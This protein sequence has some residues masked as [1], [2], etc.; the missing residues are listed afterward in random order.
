MKKSISY[1]AFLNVLKTFFSL[2]FPLITFPYASRIL[3]PEGIGKVQ[4]SH[5]IILYFTM[6]AGLG[7]GSYSV[8]EA[9]K[10]RNDEDKLTKIVKEVLII[11]LVSTF[12]AYALLVCA[13]FCIPKFHDY[14]VLLIVYSGTILFTTLGMD[15]LYTA[16]EEFQYITIR[17]F[18]FQLI[19]LILLFIFV[20]KRTDY[21]IYAAISVVSNVGSNICN[22]I[23]SRKYVSYFTKCK[24]ELKR[25]IKPIFILFGMQIV[26]SVYLILDTTVLGFISGDLEVGYY[27]AATK[28][29]KIVVALVSS[30]FTVF[31]P[32]LSSLLAENERQA[33]DDL[34]SKGIK[35]LI[36]FSIPSA[37]GLCLLSHSIILLFSG[38]GYVNAV[39]AMMIMTPIIITIS[40]SNFIGT[41]IFIPMGK[42]KLT[43]YSVIIGAIIN[44]CLNLILIPKYG[45]F[46]A[47]FATTIAETGV[48]VVLILMSR[49]FIKIQFPIKH[50]LQCIFATLLM[51]VFVYLISVFLDNI[52]IKTILGVCIGVLIYLLT[53]VLFKNE[54]VFM[55]LNKFKKR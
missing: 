28:I 5:S 51:T 11:N 25:H 47:G 40:I 42:E 2:L 21:V 41:Y 39:P 27:S 6:I 53:L 15:W 3:G 7:I 46:G 32:R 50:F 31:L 30:A 45:A 26:A 22:F 20:R 18:V 24:I 1:N 36:I 13:M 17:S 16:E 48:A 33:F 44:L 37:V 34:V 55:F 10:V 19:S 4:F 43:F 9:A 35:F 54:F 52:Y 12:I 29:N 23:H 8:R 14:K 38:Y 49:R